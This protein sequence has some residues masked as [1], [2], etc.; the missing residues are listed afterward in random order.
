MLQVGKRPTSFSL[1]IGPGRLVAQHLESEGLVQRA[2]GY[3]RANPWTINV[4]PLY[5]GTPDSDLHLL[6]SWVSSDY[7]PWVP[8][9]VLDHAAIGALG[10]HADSCL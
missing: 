6:M 10:W 2:G 8:Q 7:G 9:V 5:A 3:M 4:A 1:Y